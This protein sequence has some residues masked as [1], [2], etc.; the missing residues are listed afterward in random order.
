MNFNLT[1]EQKEIQ[2]SAREFAN[3]KFPALIIN[4]EHP[5][6]TNGE[7]KQLFNILLP[8]F[9]DAGFL[10]VT[11]P[12]K[13]G[14]YGIDTLSA[15][16]IM[17]EFSRV[18]GSG[19]LMFAVLNSLS[20]TPLLAF[21]T[22]AQKEK[23]LRAVASGEKLGAYCLTEP[24]AGSD[25]GNMA[26]TAK[27]I[28]GGWILNGSKLF[29]TH[30]S[31]A[32]FC[33]IFAKDSETNKPSAFI[34]DTSINGFGIGKIEHKAG[35]WASPTAE[36]IIK[37]CF[38]PEENLLGEKGKGMKMA[39]TTLDT[40]RLYI[41]AQALGLAQGAWNYTVDYCKKRVQFGKPIIENQG[42]YFSLADFSIHLDAARLL[43]QRAASLKDNGVKFTKE[44]SKAKIFATENSVKITSD[45]M[46]FCGGVGYTEESPLPMYCR[47]VLAT[48]IYEGANNIQRYVVAREENL[49]DKI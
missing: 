49:T 38:V 46:L 40:G 7:Y 45:C 32:D 26:T 23:Y 3:K 6:L 12:E 34:V 22:E 42:I 28:D 21:G 44:A 14:G 47:D 11:I 9:R 27:K 41:A 2:N 37:D 25:A 19:S 4:Y 31:L 29:I 17:E 16:I 36:V 35:L 10:G 8:K 20:V 30:V 33:I 39:L 15:L 5:N 18:W 43:M 48:R 1:D 24:N 13:Y